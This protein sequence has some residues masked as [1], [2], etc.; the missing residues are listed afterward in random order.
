MGTFFI[1]STVI[2]SMNLLDVQYLW[3]LPIKVTILT[4]F[5]ILGIRYGIISKDNF[6]AIGSILKSE[7]VLA[8]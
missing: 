4:V 7:K 3:S 5:L 8:A 1:G 2:A 6:R